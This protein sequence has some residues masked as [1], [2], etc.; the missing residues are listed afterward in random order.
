MGMDFLEEHKYKAQTTVRPAECTKCTTETTKVS[1]ARSSFT[2]LPAPTGEGQ[3]RWLDQCSACA[4]QNILAKQQVIVN[5]S[6]PLSL[7]PTVSN[8]VGTSVNVTVNKMITIPPAS[9]MEILSQLP[10]E[11]GPWLIEGVQQKCLVAR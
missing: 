10:A 6:E 5:Q 1:P 11:G 4:A 8:S 3:A 2:R 9:E 7:V